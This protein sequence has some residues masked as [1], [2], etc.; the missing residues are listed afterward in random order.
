[1]QIQ[2]GGG[3]LSK[4]ERLQKNQ[5]GRHFD[6]ELPASRLG[7]NK[8]L[9]FKSLSVWSFVM[10][11]LANVRITNVKSCVSKSRH[12]FGRRGS[13]AYS[14]KAPGGY[15]ERRERVQEHS[16]GMDGLGG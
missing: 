8:F 11:A 12:M 10:V 16:P 1:M 5:L 15:D 13:F 9:L 6:D 7:E 14:K 3:C 4:G 2:G